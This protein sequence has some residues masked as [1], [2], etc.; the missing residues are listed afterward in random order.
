MADEKKPASPVDRVKHRAETVR[1]FEKSF[2]P[3]N[4]KEVLAIGQK[5]DVIVG[6]A[7]NL[8]LGQNPAKAA[9][10]IASG[11]IGQALRS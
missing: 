9:K 3:F 10:A 1:E 5:Y 4:E 2:G 8:V 11:V 7:P 6:I